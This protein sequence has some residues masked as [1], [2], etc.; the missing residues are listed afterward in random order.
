[1]KFRL[2]FRRRIT[3]SP[4]PT[5]TAPLTT[6]IYKRGDTVIDSHRLLIHG[7]TPDG[8][9]WRILFEDVNS[10]STASHIITTDAPDM[11]LPPFTDAALVI[12]ADGKVIT[13]RRPAWFPESRWDDTAEIT[14]WGDQDRKDILHPSAWTAGEPLDGARNEIHEVW[15]LLSDHTHRVTPSPPKP[16]AKDS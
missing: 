9:Y 2:P 14:S 10:L 8:R 7:R 4:I 12:D 1:M 5:D 13:D 3:F 6:H 11:S 15:R 16:I